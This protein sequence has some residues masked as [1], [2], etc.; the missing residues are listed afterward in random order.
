M[1]QST[2]NV[3][4]FLTFDEKKTCRFWTMDQIQVFLVWKTWLS[5]QIPRRLRKGHGYY[6]TQRGIESASFFSQQFLC[7]TSMVHMIFW[8][9]MKGFSQINFFWK[10]IRIYPVN[11]LLLLMFHHDNNITVFLTNTF[12]NSH[13]YF[14]TEILSIR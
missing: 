3:Y 13:I 10:I 9:K 1:T 12:S 8:K 5:L 2:A 4:A 7:K 11:V 6:V 14:K